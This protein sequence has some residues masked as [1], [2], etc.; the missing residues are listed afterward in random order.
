MQVGVVGATGVVGS[1]LLGFLQ[2]RKFPYTSLRLFA[3]DR[4]FGKK[5]Q[6]GPETYSCQKLAS[7][8]FQGL[9]L[10]FFDASDEVS[11]HFVP[12]ALREGAW[13]VDNASV[14]RMQEEGFLV[15][16]EV[17]GD[18]FRSFLEKN[19]RVPCVVSGP[20][21]VVV[22]LVMVL[23]PLLSW[24][25]ERL[26][27]STY[28]S[29]SGAGNAAMQELE[30]QTRSTLEQKPLVAK[31]FPHPIAFNCIPQIGSFQ[32]DGVTSE[33]K[34][35]ILET[36]KILGRSPR[37]A[38]T[39]VR[40]PTFFCHAQSLYLEFERFLDLSEVRKALCAQPGVLL[41]DDP[42]YPLGVSEVG[43]AQG[44]DAVYVGRLRHAESPKT[45]QLWIVSDNLNKGAALNAIQLGEMVL[46]V[47]K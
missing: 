41:L 22:P 35:I 17:N 25:I 29:T 1:R 37:M 36:R 4:S 31:V 6:V 15:V 27:L 2:S 32:E 12:E 42:S 38:V 5:I 40:V 20:N 16:P 19:P 47:F 7:R 3:S 45:L 21:C 13:V 10:V 39:A 11:R 43:G 33:E 9:D 23:K 26:V 34:K 8:C 18:Q 30:A 44:R 14:F 28:Q 24:G 46:S